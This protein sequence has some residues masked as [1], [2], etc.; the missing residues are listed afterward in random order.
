VPPAPPPGG[1]PNVLQGHCPE[2]G[3]GTDEGFISA[4][5][6]YLLWWLKSSRFVG[7]VATTDI[8]G[9]P[10][11]APL[12]GDTRVSYL[13]NPLSGGRFS[14][15]YFLSDRQPIMNNEHSRDVGVE[16]TYF[17]VAQ[18]TRS[19]RND[20]AP[21]LVRPFFDLNNRRESALLIGAPGVATGNFEIENAFGG[22][23]GTELNFW[24]NL[25]DDY[26]R[27]CTRL[28]LMVGF[29]Y[30]YLYE[31]FVMKSET[32]FSPNLPASSQF[33][34]LAGSKIDVSDLF[35]T[36]NQFYGAQVGANWKAYLGPLDLNTTAKI[37][38]G[39]N[40]AHIHIEGSQLR[41][42]PDGTT[43]ISPAGLLALASNSGRFHRNLF[44][45]LPQL[46]VNAAIPVTDHFRVSLGWSFLYM[47]SVY[48][49]GAQ[50]DRALDIT[51][52]PNFPTGGAQ[53]TGLGRPGVPFK[54]AGVWT[55][56]LTLGLQYNW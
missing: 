27:S 49:P 52:I 3:D 32:I 23:W 14:V 21:L 16:L 4:S 53:P 44:S 40:D 25:Y 50:I 38:I 22:F 28:D 18:E 34:P 41:R 7:P 19:F 47:S 45:F 6:E 26:F 11:T 5:A 54:E 15:G 55:T 39:Y 9:V 20:T 33:L 43:T 48:R 10:G 8:L 24:K 51:Q 17:T 31:D 35:A 2:G 13:H 36:S 56:G 30:F 29:R 46:D 37:A 1:A 42:D 12:F